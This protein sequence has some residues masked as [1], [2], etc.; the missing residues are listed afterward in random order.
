MFLALK[1]ICS[2][3]LFINL[4]SII[5]CNHPWIMIYWYLKIYMLFHEYNNWRMLLSSCQ[6]QIKIRSR[7][8]CGFFFSL[9]NFCSLF[10]KLVLL[11][12]DSLAHF[13]LLSKWHSLGVNLD[14]EEVQ[15]EAGHWFFILAVW[16]KYLGR[17]NN[18]HHPGMISGTMPIQS[19]QIPWRQG[20]SICL[21]NS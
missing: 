18:C 21:K 15:S 8:I 12:S 19:D 10:D 13:S 14:G 7:T 3:I 2:W 11:M 9:S 16:Q 4:G 6:K 1:I 5:K 17:W 20:S